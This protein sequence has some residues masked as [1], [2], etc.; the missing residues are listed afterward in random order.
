MSF[1]MEKAL[2]ELQDKLGA[3][4]AAYEGQMKES[5]DVQQ[6]VKAD[7]KKL[8]EDHAAQLKE[9]SGAVTAVKD[10]LTGIKQKGVKLDQGEPRRTIGQQFIESESFKNYRSGG[11]GKASMQFKNTILGESGS[12]QNP[13]N[14]IVP[15]Q[16]VPGIVAGAFRA[17]RILDILP[18]GVA[19]G[20]IVHYTREASWTNSA[21][22]AK[23]GAQKA[24]STLTMESQDGYVRTIAHFLKVSKQV[25][26]DA[27]A[28]QSYI[29]VRL[30]HGVRQRLEGQVVAGNGTA[31]NLAGLA[32]ASNHTDLTFVTADNDF[33]A[34]NRA[35][36]QVIGSDYMTDTFLVNPAD[37]GR[38]E[39]TK[40][41]ISGD[42]SY[43]AG[44]DAA[45]SYLANGMQPLLWGV[46][47]I[48]SNSVTSGKFY[49]IARDA[50]MLW[51]R[52]GV[53]VEIF[54]QN[55]DDV[56]KNLLTIR[57]EM[58]AAFTVFR[59]AAVIEG[60]WPDA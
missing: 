6:G 60:S 2:T 47:V 34:A 8:A 42:K 25:L 40:S 45:I 54:D 48:M 23:E 41:G 3:K 59:P 28:L 9:L 37:W 11:S 16:T 22:E 13:T 38:L 56:E 15:L 19:T 31:P 32:N 20:N 24:E 55:E 12:P 39:R 17:L 36:Y 1:D 53:T 46:P 52:Q 18:R 4:F 27:P 50:M 33:D 21:A 51:E 5:G 26:D 57:A 29:D 30:G 10:D 58:R 44:G 35:K 7:L 14:D 49:A 43:L